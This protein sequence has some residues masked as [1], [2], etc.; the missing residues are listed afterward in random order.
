MFFILKLLIKIKNDKKVRK[1]NYEI[2][3][4]IN[5]FL[6]LYANV[7]SKKAIEKELRKREELNKFVEAYLLE[8]SAREV[9]EILKE[10]KA[11]DRKE[12]QN[13]KKQYTKNIERKM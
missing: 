13:N 1:E 2:I 8:L 6:E 11:A 3:R 9:A 7:K 12:I 5:D 10:T 4:E